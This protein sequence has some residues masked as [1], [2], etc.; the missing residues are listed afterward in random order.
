[1]PLSPQARTGILAGAIVG[2]V[3]VT[4]TV[5]MIEQLQGL[6]S[7]QALKAAHP[8]LDLNALRM[9][10]YA[11]VLIGLMIP[12]PEGLFGEREL[13]RGPRRARPTRAPVSIRPKTT[14]AVAGKG[15]P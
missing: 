15:A 1:M 9:V 4:F 12:R 7:V 14:E 2:G 10:I 11:G 13:I 3:F 5:K 8:A 6:D